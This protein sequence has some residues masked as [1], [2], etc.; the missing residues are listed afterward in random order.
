MS[1]RRIWFASGLVLALAFAVPAAD[2]PYGDPI[3]AGAKIRLGTA[4]MRNLVG[5]GPSAMTPDGK[6]LVGPAPGGG[7]AYFE[8]TTGKIVRTVKI[9]GDFGTPVSF[10]ADGKRA[11]NPGFERTIVWNTD[12]GMVIAK[13]ARGTPNDQIGASLSA[14]GKRLAVGGNKGPKDKSPSVVVWDVDANKQISLVTP[15]Q[16]ESAYAVLSPDGK[17]LATWG[18][19]RAPKAKE[20]TK[21]AADPAKQI[22]FWDVST[23][24]ETARVTL[25][26]VFNASAVVFSPD[27]TLAAAGSGEGTIHLFDPAT[28]DAKGLLLGRTRQGRKLA[29]S[30]DGKSLAAAAEDGA[31]QRWSLPD[32]KLLSTTESPAPLLLGPRAI[33]F[34]DNDRVIAWGNRDQVSLVWEVPSGKVLT[35]AGGHQSSVCSAAFAAG[36]QEIYTAASYGGQII[37]WNPTTGQELGSI[38]LKLPGDRFGFGSQVITPITLSPDGTRALV[39]DLSS[40][41]LA[42]YDLPSGIQQFLLPNEMRL[43]SNAQFSS[44]GSKAVQTLGRYDGMN[45]A[46]FVVAWDLTTGKRLGPVIELPWQVGSAGVIAA[47]GK[48]IVTAMQKEVKKPNGIVEQTDLSIVRWDVATGKKFGEYAEPGGFGGRSVAAGGDLKK[49]LAV[50]HKGVA[51]VVDLVAGKRLR[52]L[53]TGMK[54]VSGLPAVSP[55]GKTAAVPLGGTFGSKPTYSVVLFDLESGKVKRRLDGLSGSSTAITFSPD[56]KTLVTGSSDTTALVWELTR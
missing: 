55:D 20:P 32:G 5:G 6:F 25:P 13:L 17:R 15:V 34:A 48:S 19:H 3:P 46:A 24:Q 8:P 27:G 4:R 33:L 23:G 2:D 12:T 47:D 14:D 41:G 30:P 50:N 43:S 29:I 39:S 44:D 36:G 9:E 42:V 10:S 54:S 22:Q 16:N 26:G 7:I 38:A 45:N 53:D 37:R 31:V 49:V 11:I 18:Y 52:T 28:G 51:F 21:P 35:P 56:G 40:G 1:S